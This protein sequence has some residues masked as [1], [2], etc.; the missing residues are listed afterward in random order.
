LIIAQ[1]YRI[2]YRIE[3]IKHVKNVIEREARKEYSETLEK[4]KNGEEMI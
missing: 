2:E 3:E 1:I 4:L